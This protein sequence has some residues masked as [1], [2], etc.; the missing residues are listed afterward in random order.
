MSASNESVGGRSAPQ[1]DPA[2]GDDLPPTADV[3]RPFATCKAGLASPARLDLLGAT[4]L[5]EGGLTSTLPLDWQAE[6]LAFVQSACTER[7]SV[8]ADWLTL[9]PMLVIGEEGAGRTHFARQLAHHAGLPYHVWDLSREPPVS[10]GSPNAVTLPPAPLLAMLA[11]RCGN[12]II[13]VVGV[14]GA[15]GETLDQ[16]A[17]M[18]DGRTNRRRVEH[19]IGATVD[20]SHITWLVTPTT[21][22]MFPVD[23][24]PL[25]RPVRLFKPKRD[26]LSLAMLSAI[27]EAAFNQGLARAPQGIAFDHLVDRTPSQ[28]R[29]AAI[30]E[31]AHEAVQ[32][33]S[34]D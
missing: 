3:V 21:P 15:T 25:L 30:Y 27:D 23:L 9:P 13:S 33:H 5:T 22:A 29:F 14:E 18:M 28:A 11:A 34:H 16:L 17:A 32:A 8:G 26:D 6:A 2:P 20:Y 31:R 7:R 24:E 12:P 10:A 4:A 1:H 19:S